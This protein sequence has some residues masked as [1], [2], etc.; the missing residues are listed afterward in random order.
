MSKKNP[1]NLDRCQFIN[2]LSQYNSIDNVEKFSL[3]NCRYCQN[4]ST[5]EP[6]KMIK[7]YM[8]S[9]DG[10]LIICGKC[11]FRCYHNKDFIR[12]NL[13]KHFK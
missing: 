5:F 4:Y 3:I 8:M 13:D 6:R 12:H 10:K 11:K 7:H 9:H 2:E 1:F